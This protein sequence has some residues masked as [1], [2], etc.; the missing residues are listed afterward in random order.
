MVNEQISKGERAIKLIKRP[1]DSDFIQRHELSLL[2]LLV[3]RYPERAREFI[4]RLGE[5]M[6]SPA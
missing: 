3:E 6:K 1:P 5:S 2:A 4:R